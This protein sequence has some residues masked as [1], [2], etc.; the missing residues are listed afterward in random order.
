M[1]KHNNRT[2][3]SE[4]KDRIIAF[5][6]AL[7]IS[8]LLLLCLYFFVMHTPNPPYPPSVYTEVQ[9]D[10]EGGGGQ[11][12]AEGLGSP[13]TTSNEKANTNTNSSDDP[14]FASATEEPNIT[15]TK[16][17]KKPK[18]QKIKI[19][20][21][22][23]KAEQKDPQ[24]SEELMALLNNVKN[25]MDKGSGNAQGTGIGKAGSG[26][27]A[28]KGNG[29]GTGVG[30]GKGPG[31]GPGY[32]LRGR[33]LLKRPEIL[34]NSQEEGVVVVQILVDETGKVVSA[35]PGQ[36]G[37]TTQSAYLYM[38]AR[39]AAKTAQFSPSPEGIKEQK[40]TYTFVFRLN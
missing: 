38:L 8:A 23:A 36:R 2:E 17:K 26:D 6:I 28:G 25:H 12:G 27:G 11:D 21:P 34:D 30:S 4:N 15:V 19:E 14:V 40:G 37:S 10:F 16:K 13:I 35:V 24:P 22:V 32:S 7:G 5:I 9:I 3:K 29:E 31:S 20:E 39:Q 18:K 33:K 1:G